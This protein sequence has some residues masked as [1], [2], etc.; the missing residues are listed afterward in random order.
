MI[1][2]FTKKQLVKYIQEN[3][4]DIDTKLKKS[5]IVDEIKKSL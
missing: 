1:E 4:L 2:G 3:N 5:E